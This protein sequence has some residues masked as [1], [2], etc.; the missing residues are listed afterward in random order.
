MPS[1]SHE[2]RNWHWIRLTMP[3][4]LFHAHLQGRRKDRLPFARANLY[5]IWRSV[6]AQEMVRKLKKIQRSSQV[7]LSISFFGR[8]QHLACD[9]Y[10]TGRMIITMLSFLCSR[11]PQVKLRLFA[12]KQCQAG[13]AQVWSTRNFANYV[14]T[15]VHERPGPWDFLLSDVARVVAKVQK[16]A[17]SA[18]GSG[19]SEV[20]TSRKG[21]HHG[22]VVFLAW[23]C[24]SICCQERMLRFQGLLFSCEPSGVKYTEVAPKCNSSA[25]NTRSYQQVSLDTASR[26]KFQWQAPAQANPCPHKSCEDWLYLS[27]TGWIQQA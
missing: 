6:I 19:F 21:L 27:S 18:K 4:I 7:A 10:H 24:G 20:E 13:L 17:I 22:L 1:A 2:S 3:F 5:S 12:V 25:C 8:V 16:L 26:S 23:N 15:R 14:S 9:T 11:L